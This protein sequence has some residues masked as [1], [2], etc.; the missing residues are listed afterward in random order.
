MPK[1][2]N[3]VVEIE[4]RK[5][6]AEDRVAALQI[7]ESWN[8]KPRPPS[9]QVSNPERSELNVANSFVA[10]HQDR[11]VG[12]ASYI[13]L[14]DEYAETASLAVHKDYLGCNIGRRLQQARLDEMRACGVSRVRTESDRASVIDWYQRVFGYRII[15]TN[16]KKHDF[17]SSDVDHWTV[18][19]LD[20][21]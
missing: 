20:L 12:V 15:G 8:M 14:T 21:Q 16:P 11:V 13:M 19:E 18:L 7:L 5:M 4:I 6:R 10:V 2:S 1:R 9:A 3:A 17:G